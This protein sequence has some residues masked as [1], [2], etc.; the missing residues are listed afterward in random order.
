MSERQSKSVM[1]QL[2][3][4][5]LASEDD[6]DL[7]KKIMNVKVVITAKHGSDS[8]STNKTIYLAKESGGWKLLD[9]E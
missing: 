8:T 3:S 7:V 5:G 1:E 9:F 2:A 4:N 6:I